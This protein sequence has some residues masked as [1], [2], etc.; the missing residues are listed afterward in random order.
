MDDSNPQLNNTGI[1]DAEKKPLL[2]ET[3]TNSNINTSFGN[4]S[5]IE[6]FF[7]SVQIGI[8]RNYVTAEQLKNLTPIF[9]EILPNG[10][11]RY[12]S[13]KYYSEAEAET[14]R[15]AIVAKG[16]KGARVLH[17]SK[18]KQANHSSINGID[19]NTSE[20]AGHSGTK[21]NGYR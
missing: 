12:F 20:E 14:A 5:D 6:G 9:Y 17:L 15:K 13:G 8:Y 19:E 4:I 2:N 16:I 18:K 7:Y 21:V 10:T 11:N 3:I 1:K